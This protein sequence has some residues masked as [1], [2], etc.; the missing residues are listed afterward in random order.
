MTATPHLPIDYY[1]YAAPAGVTVS[2]RYI[3]V[4]DKMSLHLIDF[5]PEQN[6][7]KPWLL[8]LPGW[9]SHPTGWGAFLSE[10]TPHYRVIYLESREKGSSV[11]P[12]VDK[13]S[14]DVARMLADV[15]EAVEQTIPAGQAWMISGSSL[16]SSIALEYLA[17]AA[18]GACQPPNEAVLIAPN[19]TFAFPRWAK[20]I[21]RWFPG[22]IYPALAAIIKAYI[23]WFKVD[24]KREPEQYQKYAAT[25]EAA[26]PIKLR[27]NA[28]SLFDFDG[29]RAAKTLTTP[30]TLLGGKSDGM[31]GLDDLRRVTE[32]NSHCRLV[33]ME[34]NKATHSDK[35]GLLVKQQLD[36]IA[37]QAI[38]EKAQ[39]IG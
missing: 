19:L 9:L 14:Y 38:I 10:I 13:V 27:P 36:A 8:F 23:R 25:L 32:L 16:G 6:N 33:E 17:A 2:E 1:G 24:M 28:L 18:R 11:P 15:Q 37:E 31:H 29:W 35:A 26:D 20:P 22:R 39:N 30:T 12:M 7:D 34:S 4:S 3:T 5:Q 21:F